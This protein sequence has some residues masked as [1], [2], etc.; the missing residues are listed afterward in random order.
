MS[1]KLFKRIGLTKK[2][3][4][5]WGGH[6]YKVNR[7]NTFIENQRKGRSTYNDIICRYQTLC[8]LQRVHA[9]GFTSESEIYFNKVKMAY[10][11]YR[12]LF[13]F[14]ERILH[15]CKP[16]R[17]YDSI[18]KE[19]VP[20]NNYNKLWNTN[21]KYYCR[22]I[23]YPLSKIK[24]DLLT[25]ENEIRPLLKVRQFEDTLFENNYGRNDRKSRFW[26]N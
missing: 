15:L 4:I 16:S 6:S 8:K 2:F 23:E 10:V 25:L 19:L 13:F 1:I 11:A 9:D 18:K 12:D 7:M 22:A 5:Q 21:V 17:A 24:K 20:V 3:S 26:K 14:V